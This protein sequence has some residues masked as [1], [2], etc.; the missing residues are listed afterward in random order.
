M[1][2]TVELK[3]KLKFNPRVFLKLGCSNATSYKQPA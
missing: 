1:L 2:A 3:T